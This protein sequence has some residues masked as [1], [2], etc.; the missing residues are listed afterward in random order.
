VTEVIV[1]GKLVIGV[2]RVLRQGLEKAL[3]LVFIRGS[4]GIDSCVSFRTGISFQLELVQLN[5]CWK[6]FLQGQEPRFLVVTIAEQ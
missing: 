2:W 1:I 4:K 5:V 6:I 3:V